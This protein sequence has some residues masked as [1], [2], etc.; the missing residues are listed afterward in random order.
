MSENV[1]RTPRIEKVTVHMGVGESGKKLSNAEMIMQA[2][3]GQKP[4]RCFA[5]K[6]LPA[7]GIKKNEA[8]GCKV[9]LRGARAEK[10][11][12]TALAI[13]DKQ[14]SVKSFDGNGNFA[15]GIEE[16]TDFPGMEYDPEVGIF[17][18][19]VIV[20]LERPGYRI[21]RRKAQRQDVPAS[22]RLTVDDAISFLKAKY[23]VEV[24]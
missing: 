3:T 7:F 17:G 9:T 10:F 6:T 4:V 22:H 5:K 15:F 21:K 8:I 24:K 12:S 2:I 1:M 13:K 16:H 14:L 18:M 19:D 20:S 11:L 23:G